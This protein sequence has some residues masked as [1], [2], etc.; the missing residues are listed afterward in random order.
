MGRIFSGI[1]FVLVIFFT[2]CANLQQTHSKVETNSQLARLDSCEKFYHAL[3][4]SVLAENIRDTQTS[5]I[6][7]SAF[8]DV[9]RFL[10][11]YKNELNNADKRDFWLKIVAGL[12]RKKRELEWANLSVSAKNTIQQRFLRQSSFDKRLSSCSN[13]YL[14]RLTTHDKNTLI[15][16]A[17]VEDDYSTAMRIFG[18]YPLSSLAV[19][20]R[21]NKHHAVT[22]E[23]FNKPLHQ[24]NID[25]K[26]QRYIPDYKP[27]AFE[28]SIKQENPLGIPFIPTTVLN[29]LFER[30]A[31]VLEIDEASDADKIGKIELNDSNSPFVNKNQPVV[32]TLL[33]YTRFNGK[34][35]AQLNYIF[36]FPER[37]AEKSMDI[38]AGKFD[39]ITWRVT[40]DENLQPI[41]FDSD[42]NCGCYHKFYA[43]KRL[44][45][46]L[47]S[48]LKEK[49]PPFLAQNNLYTDNNKPWVIRISSGSHYIQRV[50]QQKR[51]DH[52]ANF[53]TVKSYDE[54]RSLNGIKLNRNLFAS[55]GIL[56]ESKR[57]ERFLLWPMGIPSAGAM[58]QW[59]HHAIAFVGKRYFDEPYLL[60]KYFELKTAK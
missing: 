40:L 7:G 50:Y 55:N 23:I 44:A 13:E 37:P 39:G 2:G 10:V 18:I 56:T 60:D 9:N 21:I 12:N 53:Y 59:G 58:R 4:E 11:S 52:A 6:A 20:N 26:L 33:S 17:N 43:T 42:H 15:Q 14:K 45:F 16:Q 35:L 41:M 36:W 46:N 54:L 47:E 5:S 34:T 19:K 29:E 48:A 31:P 32:Y 8:L 1:I 30:Y 51:F 3:D 25:G 38:Y 27:L 57:A 49:E 28:G 22:R 24:L